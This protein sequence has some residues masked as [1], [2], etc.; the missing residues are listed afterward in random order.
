MPEIEKGYYLG[1]FAT[2]YNSDSSDNINIL[3]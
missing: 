2:E 1:E 3:P